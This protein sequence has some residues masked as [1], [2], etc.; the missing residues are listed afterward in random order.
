MDAALSVI[1]PPFGFLYKAKPL[2]LQIGGEPHSNRLVNRLFQQ[3]ARCLVPDFDGAFLSPLMLNKI[4]L[5]T[6]TDR[7]WGGR[8][9]FGAGRSRFFTLAR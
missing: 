2:L 1:L 9:A 3:P 4:D 5:T 7:G 8:F 6:M